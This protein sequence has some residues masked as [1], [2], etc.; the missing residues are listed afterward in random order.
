M[1][2]VNRKSFPHSHRMGSFH[3]HLASQAA[4]VLVP[5]AGQ[6]DVRESLLVP[7]CLL[8]EIGLKTMRL[9]AKTRGDERK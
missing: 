3:L 9:W 4:I 1:G 6:D 7:G 5:L 2:S 8:L